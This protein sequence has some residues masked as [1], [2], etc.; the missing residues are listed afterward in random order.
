[1]ATRRS[2]RRSSHDA[3]DESRWVYDEAAAERAVAFLETL[4][5]RAEDG[6]DGGRLKLLDWQADRI[7]R[8]LFGWKDRRT[9]RRRYRRVSAWVPRG[10]GKTPLAVGLMLCLMYGSGVQ[11][12]EFYSVAADREQAAISFE[13][14]KHMVLTAPT[15]EAE[16]TVLRRAMVYRQRASSWK[17]L[18]SEAKTKHGTRPLGV[19]FDELHTQKKREL[20]AAMKTGLGKGN[21]DTLLVTISTA[22]IY[23]VESLA[24]GEYCY[25]KKVADGVVDD[26]H[27]LAVI[28]EADPA[29][30]QDGRWA[31]P[32]VWAAC[33][34]GI[35]ITVQ[36]EVLEDEARQAKEDPAALAEFLQLRLNIWVQATQAAILP[37][38]WAKCHA[39]DLLVEAR[40]RA[41]A[42]GD[43]GEK[44]DLTALA[45]WV[46][47]ADGTH[48]VHT[49]VF[50][51]ESK[52]VAL[53]H[54][55]GVD[56][57]D[58][59]RGGWVQW[60]GV[61]YVDTD[62]MRAW[63]RARREAFDIREFAFD[64]WNAYRF[65]EQLAGE[66]RITTVELP[67]T[68]KH[69]SEATKEF[70]QLIGD[71]KIRTGGNPVLRWM[72]SNLV[73]FR[74][75]K[76]NVVPQKQSKNAKIDG[77]VA[78]INAFARARVAPKKA[79]AKVTVI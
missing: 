60:S 27:L 22:G 48:S 39:Q 50:M 2:K 8:P 45:L 73:L 4:R 47:H 32:E 70:L 68:M 29:V 64:P 3:G 65:A 30:A 10:N 35:G 79:S 36:R 33:N 49:Q 58:W 24:Y 51:P 13:D 54:K 16:T 53:G 59:H 77:I 15:L 52:A 21:R 5:L 40:P 26:P 78:A 14:A 63:L 55:H 11:G 67:Q 12:G 6:T 9:G 57:V 69:L 46:P 28:F 17:V 43:V 38:H 34:P 37:E 61:N 42:G 44:D 18:S 23:D 56:Y 7:V 74:D 72:A 76:S 66:D 71:G 20:F 19:L 1:M 75:G 62:D 41:W 25:A 31:D